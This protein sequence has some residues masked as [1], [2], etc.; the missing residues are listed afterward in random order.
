MQEKVTLTVFKLNSIVEAVEILKE[1]GFPPIGDPLLLSGGEE[2][3]RTIAFLLLK[4]ETAK[5][6]EAKF[7]SLL[8]VV[9]SHFD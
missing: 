1:I 9:K 6:L 3:Q 2:N 4:T 7:P 8:G 5:E